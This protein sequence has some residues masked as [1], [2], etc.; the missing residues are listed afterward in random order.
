MED[1][2]ICELFT[3]HAHIIWKYIGVTSAGI[4]EMILP[5]PG[6]SFKSKMLQPGPFVVFVFIAIV[7]SLLLQ[8]GSFLIKDHIGRINHVLGLDKVVGGSNTG[9]F[10]SASLS[11]NHVYEELKEGIVGVYAM[12]GRRGNMEDRFSIFQD[13]EVGKNKKMSFFGVY[14]GHGGQ[15]RPIY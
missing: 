1:E 2:I 5:G 4:A 14:D 7:A 10:I 12:Q 6:E 15:V 9:S 11:G 3:T 13:V 8:S